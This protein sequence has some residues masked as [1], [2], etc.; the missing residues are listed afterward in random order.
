METMSGEEGRSL[1]SWPSLLGLLE[2][3][4]SEIAERRRKF[5]RAEFEA[6][7]FSRVEL[8]WPPTPSP[9]RL[10]GLLASH[11]HVAD[12]PP[13]DPMA[14]DSLVSQSIGFTPKKVP[15][16]EDLGLSL[17]QLGSLATQIEP[18]K[19][20]APVVDI[21]RPSSHHLHSVRHWSVRLVDDLDWPLSAISV[22]EKS[23]APKA[24]QRTYLVLVDLL[25]GH[26]PSEL[27]LAAEIRSFWKETP[28]LW[29]S[30]GKTQRKFLDWGSALALASS[31]EAVPDLAEI[32]SFLDELCDSWSSY[33]PLWG[34]SVRKALVRVLQLS[35]GLNSGSPW[36]ALRIAHQSEPAPTSI[37]LV[38]MQRRQRCRDLGMPP[39]LTPPRCLP[40]KSLD[41]LLAEAPQIGR[42][43]EF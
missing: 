28:R 15:R 42:R 9:K 16:L 36:L 39:I 35:S 14:T 26:F 7:P 1:V 19:A 4:Q 6:L 20:T 21:D 37:G 24:P 10:G 43:K 23:L 2:S 41:D 34:R 22:V 17:E 5:G 25:D 12:V 38:G 33:Y 13:P 18:P 27:A 30:T 8:S 40:L 11:V 29:A 3:R 32:A 31:F